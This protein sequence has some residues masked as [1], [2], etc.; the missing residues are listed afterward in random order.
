[1]EVPDVDVVF[2]SQDIIKPEKRNSRQLLQRKIIEFNKELIK[3]YGKNNCDTINWWYYVNL[4]RFYECKYYFDKLN[5][6]NE[7]ENQSTQLKIVRQCIQLYKLALALKP[8]CLSIAWKF[9]KL[10]DF[11]NRDNNNNNKSSINKMNAGNAYW[12]QFLQ[13]CLVNQNGDKKMSVLKKR[14]KEYES[15]YLVL[16]PSILKSHSEKVILPFMLD[17][18][19]W[20]KLPYK[21]MIQ[22][23]DAPSAQ[24]KLFG[25]G[26]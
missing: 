11:L 24:T 17:Q 22:F 26:I 19:S 13:D 5:E 23:T 25:Q 9:T 8:N 16:I 4:A 2:G 21:Q 10:L 7:I 14:I 12:Q 20:F 15:D 1:M 6:N 3:N 18:S